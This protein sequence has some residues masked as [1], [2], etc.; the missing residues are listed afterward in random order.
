MPSPDVTSLLHAWSEGDPAARDQLIP[1]VY[2]ELRRR[3]AVYLRQERRDR[4]LQPT[5]LVHEA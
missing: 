1:L 3:A 2:D 5:A 4:T